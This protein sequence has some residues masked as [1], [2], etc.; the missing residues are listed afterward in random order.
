MDQVEA[1]LA[2]VR[3]PS[4][5]SIGGPCDCSVGSPIYAKF[6]AYVHVYDPSK[7]GSYLT[8]SDSTHYEVREPWHF[9]LSRE[10]DSYCVPK[11]IAQCQNNDWTANQLEAWTTDP[12][13]PSVNIY[14]KPGPCP[15]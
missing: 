13:A 4:A 14:L 1:G 7:P 10:R 5:A 9:G 12:D 8:P 3:T 11:A 15:L 2:M 6:V